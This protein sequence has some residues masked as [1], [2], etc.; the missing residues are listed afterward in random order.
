M[1]VWAKK[2]SGE[3]QGG[4]VNK[5]LPKAASPL[6]ILELMGTGGPTSPRKF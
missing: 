6:F 4:S 3:V 1:I 2:L 5:I